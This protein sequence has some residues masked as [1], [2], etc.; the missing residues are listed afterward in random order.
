MGKQP[1]DEAS[2]EVLGRPVAA[3]VKGGYAVD[4]REVRRGCEWLKYDQEGGAVK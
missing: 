3:V 2:K 1:G 4:L